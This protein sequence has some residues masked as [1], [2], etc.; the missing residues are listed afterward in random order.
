MSVEK[1]IEN[2]GSSCRARDGERGLMRTAY[3]Q[4]GLYIMIEGDAG[5]FDTVQLQP[6]STFR[7]VINTPR[8]QLHIESCV[9]PGWPLRGL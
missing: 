3:Q 8:C 2:A 6:S 1:A 5:L 4:Y 9:T 7:R